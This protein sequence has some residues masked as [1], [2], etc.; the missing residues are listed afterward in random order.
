MFLGVLHFSSI[1]WCRSALQGGLF[2]AQPSVQ[3]GTRKGCL[4]MPSLLVQQWRRFFL[5]C[6]KDSWR[7]DWLACFLRVF[8]PEFDD[9]LGVL[10]RF[11]ICLAMRSASWKFGYSHNV[12]VIS[13]VPLDD[14]RVVVRVHRSLHTFRKAS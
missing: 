1:R 9:F 10:N 5:D 4:Y 14:H 2:F 11:R 7:R 8:Y 3:P 12:D 13:G 6:G